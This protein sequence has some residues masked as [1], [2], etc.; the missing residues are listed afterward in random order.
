MLLP[1]LGDRILASEGYSGQMTS[2][3]AQLDRS[4]NLFKPV[5]TDPGAHGRFDKIARGQVTGYNPVHLR[6][7]IACM[8]IAGIAGLMAITYSRRA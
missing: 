5:P 4:D 2:H 1:L 3:A 7:G 8:L 6:A